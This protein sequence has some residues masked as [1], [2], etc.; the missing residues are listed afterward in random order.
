MTGARV[1]RLDV[2]RK[3]HPMPGSPLGTMDLPAWPS[4]RA[5]GVGLRERMA[6]LEEQA[7]TV[8]RGAAA[9]GEGGRE[10]RKVE[11][12]VFSTVVFH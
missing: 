10:R 7:T 9:R 3:G 6:L 12:T 5:K 2:S 11:D 4:S 1:R 8:I